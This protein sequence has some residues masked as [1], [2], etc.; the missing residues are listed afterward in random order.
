[1]EQPTQDAKPLR[2]IHRTAV[3][4]FQLVG[5]ETVDLPAQLSQALRNPATQQA[6][7]LELTR[8]AEQGRQRQVLRGRLLSDPVGFS[9]A[10]AQQYVAGIAS[11][12][13]PLIKQDV[14]DQIKDTDEYDQFYECAEQ[15][16]TSFKKT[17]PGVWVVDQHPKTF[18]VVAGVLTLGGAIAM[19]TTR[20]GDHVAKLA[21]SGASAV[22][23]NPIDL[24]TK[25]F[26]FSVGMNRFEPSKRRIDLNTMLK[27]N[28]Q[29]V[30]AQ[31][32]A[33]VTIGRGVQVAPNGQLVVAVGRGALSAAVNSPGQY[34]VGFHV[35]Q[36][37]KGPLDLNLFVG[38]RGS[39]IG[40]VSGS[41]GYDAKPHG[42]NLRISGT[43]ES[44]RVDNKTNTTFGIVGSW[45]FGGPS[46]RI[47]SST[48]KTGS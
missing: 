35:D 17:S 41:L 24:Q 9:E 28:W 32:G 42:N 11:K 45:S 5:A 31:L 25:A 37:P 10:E 19:Y 3:L 6:I 46:V 4:A 15:A 22:G 44:K 7:G 18:Y 39:E 12:S 33:G 8:I 48:R 30:Q 26:D 13:M 21:I 23:A 20:S 43:I 2:V 27:G 38:F 34:T 36:K 29:P 47:S 14:I 1:V 16:L 40:S